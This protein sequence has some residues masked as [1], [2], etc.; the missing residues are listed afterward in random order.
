VLVSPLYS[1]PLIELSL[2][3]PAD[4]L[5]AEGRDRGLARQAFADVV[6]KP[7]LDRQWKD[8]SGSFHE[9]LI[10]RHVEWLRRTLLDGVLVSEGLLD[11]T[12]VDL[13]LSRTLVKTNVSSDEILRHLNAE[14]W[15]RGWS[16]GSA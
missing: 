6:P 4:V 9:L 8:R 14:L 16:Y 1:Q 7:I 2:R 5:F 13:A 3:I 11:R 10:A 12:Q 15:A